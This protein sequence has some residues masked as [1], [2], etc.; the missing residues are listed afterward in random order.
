M[1][2]NIKNLVVLS[3]SSL[4]IA[5]CST[6]F[7]ETE[8][9]G[10]NVVENYYR[11][12]AEATTGLVAVYDL[13]RK[14][15]G[16]FEN[17]ITMFNAA[18]DDQ[19][20]NGGNAS[21][22]AGIQSFSNYT[23]N[24][25][26][27]PRSFFKDYYRGIYRAN[28]LLQKIPGVPMSDATKARF[29]AEARVLRAFYYFNLVRMFKNVPLILEPL[30]ADSFYSVTQATPEAVYAQIELDL[31]ESI[32]N[33]PVTVN[34]AT[35]GGRLTQGSAKAIL[36]KVYLYQG[37]N[38]LAAAQFFDVNGTPGGTSQYGYKLLDNYNDLWNFSNR[39]NTESVLEVA[40]SAQG[41]SWGNWGGN[42]D[43][44]NSVNQMVGPRTYTRSNSSAPDLAGGWS[45]NQFTQDFYDFMQGDPRFGATI[46]DLKALRDANQ[47]DYID[48]Y[49][50][51]GYYLNKFMPKQSDIYSGPGDAVLNFTQNTYAI[52][53]ADTYLMEAE[54]LGG[55]GT[56]AQALLDAV[57]ARVGLPSI[58]V[59]L[60]TIKDERRR[61]LA[62]EGHRWFDLV[63]WGD[64]PTKLAS[65]GFVAGKNE[66]LP[67]PA[68]DLNGTQLV[69]NPNYPN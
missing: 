14:N 17:M 3:L 67:I 61:E 62:G 66:I 18:S 53:L 26:T 5:S 44:G 27:V 40:H 22:G 12:E 56:R 60:G 65:R 24:A 7:I 49:Q 8:P 29:T 30:A 31:T 41:S 10:L 11:N 59:S 63:R 50:D 4:M 45:F 33:L 1:K 20:A 69:Q 28:L 37:K 42:Q 48:G 46:L 21:D 15:S 52:R 16:G 25:N 32:A 54:A 39:F 38:A 55:T 64:A 13:M 36:G 19:M 2:K 43:E 23:I 6:D 35:D 9:T 58:A 51:T 68:F 47:V 34:V 57:R